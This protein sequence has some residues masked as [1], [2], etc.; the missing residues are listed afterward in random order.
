LQ[1]KSGLTKL[2]AEGIETKE[3]LYGLRALGCSHGQGYYFSRSLSAAAAT[4]MIG[5]RFDV[6]AGHALRTGRDP[7]KTAAG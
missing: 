4:D 6:M 2:V 3:Q 5:K 7:W 1:R